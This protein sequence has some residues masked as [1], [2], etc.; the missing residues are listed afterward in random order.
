MTFGLPNALGCDQLAILCICGKLWERFDSAQ[1][2][3][4]AGRNRVFNNLRMSR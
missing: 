2:T 3:F 4:Q 1:P